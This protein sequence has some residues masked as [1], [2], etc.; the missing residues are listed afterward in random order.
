MFDNFNLESFNTFM[1]LLKNY[2]YYYSYSDD[3]SV[4][5]KGKL[6]DEEIQRI[7]N[8]NIKFKNVYK[9]WHKNY[10]TVGGDKSSIDAINAIQESLK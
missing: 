3:K 8:K 4:Y 5:K 7:C 2:D 9:F 6:Q 10:T 1:E